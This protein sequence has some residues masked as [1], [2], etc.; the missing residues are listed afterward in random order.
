M[1][2]LEV[3]RSRLERSKVSDRDAMVAALATLVDPDPA[4]RA[5]TV[6]EIHGQDLEAGDELFILGLLLADPDEGVRAAAVAAAAPLWPLGRLL[7][8]EERACDREQAAEGRRRSEDEDG[9][10]DEDGDED[11]GASSGDSAG[12]E[13]ADELRHLLS[14]L[15]RALR[16]P[17]RGV[18]WTAAGLLAPWLSPRPN[19]RTIY[20]PGK[21]WPRPASAG[22]HLTACLAAAP[23]RVGLDPDVADVLGWRHDDVAAWLAGLDDEAAGSPDALVRMLLLYRDACRGLWPSALGDQLHR[24]LGHTWPT[25]LIGLALGDR[26][27]GLLRPLAELPAL[28]DWAFAPIAD[29]LADRPR[30]QHAHIVSALSVIHAIADAGRP[31]PAPVR[32]RVRQLVA[33]RAPGASLPCLVALEG[34]AGARDVLEQW[35]QSANRLDRVIALRFLAGPTVP[36]D[37]QLGWLLLAAQETEPL[38]LSEVAVRMRALEVPPAA[39]PRAR[40]VIASLAHHSHPE[41]R[42]AAAAQLVAWS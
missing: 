34:E 10:D 21:P 42:A 31:V 12:S 29:A 20:L 19:A 7:A 2:L 11:D 26:V 14:L 23:A 33:R 40:Q 6:D 38:L 37:E 22:D 16:D 30:Q 36:L 35:F 9:D 25:A 18:R 28:P 27:W 41:L 13:S 8:S 4:L 15:T 1:S 24:R 39:R 3:I 17:A 32:A 5:L